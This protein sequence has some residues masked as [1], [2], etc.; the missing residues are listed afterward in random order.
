LIFLYKYADNAGACLLASVNAGGEN[1]ARS[2]ALGALLGAAHGID[3]IESDDDD[4]DDDE[5]QRCW[6]IDG[7]AE[8]DAV[9]CS[10]EALLLTP[11]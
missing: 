2:S 1:V 5:Q 10:V 8:R 6:L 4:D 3:A 7:L 11:P 9:W